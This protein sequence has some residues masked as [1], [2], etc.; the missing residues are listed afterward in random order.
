[1]LYHAALALNVPLDYFF[2]AIPPGR[3][4]NAA[5]AEPGLDKVALLAVRNIQSLP[6]GDMRQTLLN[7]IADLARAPR[8]GKRS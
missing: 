5:S 1:M 3:A 7:L 4:D 6:G 2:A 8:T